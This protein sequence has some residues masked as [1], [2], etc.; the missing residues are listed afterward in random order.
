V[1]VVSIAVTVWLLIKVVYFFEETLNKIW[2]SESKRSL[3]RIMRKAFLGWLVL[4]T[5][6]SI[7]AVSSGHGVRSVALELTGTWLFFLGFNKALPDKRIEWKSVF[8]GSLIAGTAWYASKWGF[9][10][11]MQK[12][13]KP[14]QIYAILGIL[15]LFL[16]WLYFSIVML[17]FS[18]CLNVSLLHQ[19][20][21]R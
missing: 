5:V 4:S 20:R 8:P 12:L 17:L 9:T 6:V 11:Y 7:G 10:A 1:S 13:A 16:L 21:R 15:P 19:M 18:A 2:M 14:E 3:P